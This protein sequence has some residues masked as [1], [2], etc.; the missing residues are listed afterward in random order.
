MR[1]RW[2]KSMPLPGVG[3]AVA[4]TSAMLVWP[5]ARAFWIACC[6]VMLLGNAWP[7][8]P[9]KIVSVARPRIFGPSTASA[10]L[11]SASTRTSATFA[12]CGRSRRSKRRADGPKFIDFSAGIPALIHGGPPRRASTP[13]IRFGITRPF[14]AVIGLPSLRSVRPPEGFACLL[15]SLRRRRSLACP[16]DGRFGHQ[17]ASHAYWIRSAGV[18]HWP[19]LPTVGS[20]TRGLR[21]LIGFAPQASLTGLPSLRSVRPPEGF[22]CSLDSLHKRRSSWQPQQPLGDDVALDLVGARV[23]RTGEREQVAVGPLAG[24]LRIRAEEVERGLVQRH[25]ELRPVQLADRRLRAQ[26]ATVEQFGDRRPGVQLVG[27]RADP[28][29]D[30]PVGQCGVT[31]PS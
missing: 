5:C 10:T 28:C 8:K 17:R 21:M 25:V 7:R 26:R 1:P 12:R 13:S 3:C 15:D 18:A 16:P 22:A 27:T 31:A 2:S 19:S 30:R 29:V 24:E 9:V 4:R 6:N 23:D 14:G 11:Q 20:A